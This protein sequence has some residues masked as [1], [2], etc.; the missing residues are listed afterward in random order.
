[1]TTTAREA[2]EIGTETFDAHDIDG[3]AEVLAE[4]PS[5]STAAGSAPSPTRASTC[6]VFTSLTTLPSRRAR[7]RA[8]TAVC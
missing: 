4:P 7:S 8:R 3:L 1:M 2:F 5:S 6:V